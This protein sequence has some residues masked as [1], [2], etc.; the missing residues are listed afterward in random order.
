MKVL[1]YK[2]NGNVMTR[3]RRKTR[4]KKV[5]PE[6][7]KK[8]KRLR[9]EGMSYNKIAGKLGLSVMTVYNHLKK[10]EKTGLLDKLKRKLSL[11]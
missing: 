1:Q 11:R 8:M 2:A 9:R 3:K 10:K 7:I 5:S 4:R 6:M